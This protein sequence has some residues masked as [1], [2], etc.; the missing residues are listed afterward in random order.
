MPLSE[1]VNCLITKH[2]CNLISRVTLNL[3]ANWTL[4]PTAF[5]KTHKKS[6]LFQKCFA[7]QTT[8]CC[9][10]IHSSHSGLQM[11][12]NQFYGQCHTA[13]FT[14]GSPKASLMQSQ[15]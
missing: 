11:L 1:K 9:Y 3:I 7:L 6:V 8:T 13:S 4:I 2:N 10:L 5:P 14:S 15:T 12:T